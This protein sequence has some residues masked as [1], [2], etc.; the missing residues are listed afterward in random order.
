MSH[1]KFLTGQAH[2]Q[3]QARRSL[4][5]FF[6]TGLWL[7]LASA[8]AETAPAGNPLYAHA[9]RFLVVHKNEMVLNAGVSPHWRSAGGAHFTYAKE[10]G[11]GRREFI[12]VDAATGKRR[13]AFQA[14]IVAAGLA[15]ALGESVDAQRLPFNDYDVIGRAEIQFSVGAAD[16]RCS[17][18]RPTCSRVPAAPAVDPLVVP[19]P[20][21][22]WLAYVQNHN[23]WVRSA[24]GK[25]R[26]ALTQDG[27]AHNAYAATPEANPLH[28]DQVMQGLPVPPVALWSP[29]SRRV[30]TQ[31]MDEREVRVQV[32]VQSTPADGS[33]QSK[34]IRWRSPM[35]TDAVL[36]MAES[37]IFDVER[38]EG[39]RVDMPPV[40][41]LVATAIENKEAWWTDDSQAV[42]VF[43]RSRYNKQMSLRRVNAEDGRA[44]VVV[45]EEGATFV[46]AASIGGRPMVYILKNG[47]VLWF[48]ERTGRGHLYL[49]DGASGALLRP[50]TQ[51]DWS[52]RNVLRLDEA[53]GYVYVAGTEREAGSDPYYRK[54]Y[55]I[56]LADGAVRLLSP[57]EAD[58]QVSCEQE[59]AYFSPPKELARDASAALGFSPDGKYFLDTYSRTDLPSVTVLRRADGGEVAVVEKADISRLAPSGVPHPERFSALAADGKTRLYGNLLRPA[60][61]DPQKKYPIVDSLYPGPQARKA[62]PR[63]LDVVFGY[64][65]DQAL[66][67][68]GFIVL[69]M[70]GRGTP[71]RSKTFLDESYGKLGQ[72]GHLDDHIAVLQQLA[73]KDPSLDLTR[74]GV[75]GGSAGG[76]AA[77]RAMLLYPEFYK[78]AV[79]AAGSH[80]LRTQ[81]ASYSEGFMGP[82]DG[83]NYAA[84]ANAPLVAKLQGPLLLLHGEMDWTVA[85]QNTLQVVAALIAHDKP[86]DLIIAP[87][88]GHSP[89]GV[90]GGYLLQRSWDFLSEHLHPSGGVLPCIT[91]TSQSCAH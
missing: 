61:F 59:S 74:V 38:R 24:D 32:L 75:Y 15:S 26:F 45:Q 39:H 54:I 66:A 18:E 6:A 31:R 23:L 12:R 20:D 77:L 35:A 71:G 36:P 68:L 43:S 30:F 4:A 56:S 51:G 40:A 11:D 14:S 28:M 53:R 9:E 80:D 16:Y 82:D 58:H 88:V 81:T 70:D 22:R 72:A 13:P 33:V 5:L 8:Q 67:E 52:V 10:L 55:R 83:T 63:Y 17:V 79:S 1:L 50:L 85:P 42:Y 65:A 47:Q 44:R 76:Y 41:A 87:N 27:E 91:A 84:A 57:E 7:A 86:F 78:V 60:N 46:E 49:Y 19:S 34:T 25:Q 21:G 73:A 37:W 2:G 3:R 64:T 89:L 90:H 62:Y 69:Q 48:S 29:D